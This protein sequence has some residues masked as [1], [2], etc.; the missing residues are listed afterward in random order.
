MEDEAALPL[1]VFLEWFLR[2]V[3]N[4]VLS[5]KENTPWVSSTVSDFVEVI[6]PFHTRPKSEALTWDL[7]KPTFASIAEMLPGQKAANVFLKVVISDLLIPVMLL[8]GLARSKDLDMLSKRVVQLFDDL[9]DEAQ[10]AREIVNAL[11]QAS[12]V[13]NAVHWIVNMDITPE[14]ELV[15]LDDLEEVMQPVTQDT[16]PIF[17][18]VRNAIKQSSV[19]KNVYNTLMGKRQLITQFAP[20]IQDSFTSIRAINAEL[21]GPSGSVSETQAATIEG[22][23]AKFA[24]HGTLLPPE[25]CRSFLECLDTASKSFVQCAVQGDPNL[26]KSAQQVLNKAKV[27]FVSSAWIIDETLVL[28][29]LLQVSD[30]ERRQEAFKT[31]YH[32]T[33]GRGADRYCSY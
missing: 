28:E 25:M 23:L 2:R 31:P 15:G 1:D 9:P 8:P 29:K 18:S 16:V 4:A 19:W 12:T 22:T 27:V 14:T 5:F 24:K 10:P 11:I 21:A 13:C 30:I 3:G 17:S 33:F 32:T 6:K 26:Q 20:E 7:S